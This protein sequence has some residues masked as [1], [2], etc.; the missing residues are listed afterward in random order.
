MGG[1]TGPTCIANFAQGC[2]GGTLLTCDSQSDCSQ[3]QV[4]CVTINAAPMPDTGPSMAPKFTA[5]CSDSCMPADVLCA[6]NQD[7]VMSQC[8]NTGGSNGCR[9]GIGSC[10]GPRFDVCNPY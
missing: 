10:A 2:A 3:K 6:T 4:C 7:C 5:S 8:Q 9:L 1:G